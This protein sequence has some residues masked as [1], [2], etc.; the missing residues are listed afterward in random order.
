VSASTVGTG[1]GTGTMEGDPPRE[2]SAV[3]RPRKARVLVQIGGFLRKEAASIL[4][5]PR[6]LLVLVA[7]PFLILLLFGVGYDQQTVVLRTAFVG[8]QGAIYE[9]TLDEFA[10]SLSRYVENAGYT[11][12]VVAAEQE[13]RAGNIDA[14]VVF[15]PDPAAEVLAGEQASITVLHDKIDPIQVT[16]VEVSARVA[17][18]ELNARILEEVI[19]RTQE[20]LVPFQESLAQASEQVSALNDAVIRVDEREVDR[21]LND[22]SLSASALDTLS[23]VSAEI[24]NEIGGDPETRESLE[25]LTAST[26]RLLS[27]VSGLSEA[28]STPSIEELRQLDAELTEVTEIGETAVTLD[29]SVVV[30]PFA[31]ETA[32]LQREGV[33]VDD[34][35]APAALALLL[36]HMVLTFAAMSLVT[37]RTLGLFEVFRVGPVD[38]ARVMAGKYLAFLL[39]GAAVAAALL[40]LV[41][42]VLGVPMRGDWVWVAVGIGGLLAASIGFGMVLSLL[43][44]SDVQAVQYAMLALLSALFFGGFFLSLDAFLYPVKLV[45]WVLP[46]SYATRLLRDV[47]LRGVDPNLWDLIGLAGTTIGFAV[48]AW[49]LLR[50]QLSVQ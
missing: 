13:L 10:D 12:D 20:Q 26:D 19:R 28:G 29:P 32:N 4:R 49:Y 11:D 31:S 17:I 5:Q 43:A 7:G 15:P 6:L 37:D 50:R 8:P 14:I 24:T 1:R 40:A 18:L 33:A 23:D 27:T 42:L 34:F 21:I 41:V 36:Q 39:I 48:V 9:E 47:M 35:F 44:R 2:R 22:L 45:S 3:P 25:R 38:A 46:V 30:R 16:A